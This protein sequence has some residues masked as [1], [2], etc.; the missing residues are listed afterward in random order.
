M[1]EGNLRRNASFALVI[2]SI[3]IAASVWMLDP[4][5]Q[6]EQIGVLLGAELVTFGMIVY[7]YTRPNDSN[8]SEFWLLVGVIT[9][10]FFIG[11]ATL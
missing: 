6:Q 2:L 10:A 8:V 11:L 1:S 5:K 9:I 3:A 7:L 4:V